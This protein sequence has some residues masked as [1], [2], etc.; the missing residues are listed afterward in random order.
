MQ[1]LKANKYLLLASLC[2][3]IISGYFIWNNLAYL[4]LF[5]IVLIA[6]FMAIFYGEKMFL[7]LA[8]LTPFS[9]N[10]EEYTNSFGLFIPTEPLLFGFLL[11]GIWQEL[12]KPSLTKDF[13]SSPIVLAVSFYLFWMF[14]TAITST[15]QVTSFKFLLAHCWLIIPM[16]LYG[17]SVF[18]K[19]K[20]IFIFFWLFTIAM[21]VV[22]SY[23]LVIHYGYRF[24]EKE[25]HWVMWPFYK[26]H[27]IY[28]ASIGLTVPMVF[29]LYFY[30]KHNAIVQAVIISLMIIV[31]TGFYFSYTRGAWLSVIFALGVWLLIKFRIK[32][33]WIFTVIVIAGIYAMTNWTVIE[34]SLGR[35][36]YEHTTENFQNRVQSAANVST[37]ASNLER[38]NRWQCAMDMVVE[39]PI[40]GFGPGTY[41]FEYA[42]FQRPQNL[43]IISTN[44]GNGGNAHSE[45]LGAMAETGFVGMLSVFILVACI[46]YQSITLYLK[47]PANDRKIRVV[48]MVIILS[49]STYFFHGLLNN[50][51][52]T[53]KASIPVYGMCSIVLA[54]EYKWRQAQKGT[55]KGVE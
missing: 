26:D 33:S 17:F 41:A 3:L 50:Y 16:L 53:D 34:H 38:L 18:Q 32:F 20:N 27:T 39:K 4:T 44:F 35:N 12:K 11:L 5:P 23:T 10:I 24:G 29:G 9:I 55:K 21:A 6:I 22:I 51:L 49:L 25:S 30:K 8:F 7:V 1:T 47:W 15:N 42:R 45:Y 14:I 40:F 54:L 37:D 2:Y 13:W 19:E 28:G 52:D 31:L 43:T 46:F 36:K 48:L